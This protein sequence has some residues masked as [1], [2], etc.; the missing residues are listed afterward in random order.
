MAS[1]ALTVSPLDGQRCG[2]EALHLEQ[3][4]VQPLPPHFGIDGA[5]S[6]ADGGYALWSA[7]SALLFMYPDGLRERR[8]LPALLHPVGLAADPAGYRF[9]DRATGI[10]YRLGA[11]SIP[12]RIGAMPLAPGEE[13]DA[14]R[15]SD[16]AWTLGL[17]DTRARRFLVRRVDG[18]GVT[19]LFASAAA[20]SVRHISRYHLS[21]TGSALLLTRLTEPFEVLR[22]ELATG[23]VDTLA[24]PFRDA[25]LRAALPDT[26]AQWRALPAVALDCGWLLTLSDLR[27]DRR[28]LLRYDA[29]GGLAKVTPLDAPFG[30]MAGRPAE[31]TLLAAR[32]AGELELVWYQWRWVRQDH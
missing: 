30:V 3:L 6:L 11:D 23:R 25:A 1:L 27:S 15:W 9:L 21:E 16:G 28:L 10:E 24:V 14:A 7:E 4:A 19:T 17:R 12:E 2:P 29:S 31:G 20:D 26:V 5:L 32:R 22:L 8:A 18:A 13:L